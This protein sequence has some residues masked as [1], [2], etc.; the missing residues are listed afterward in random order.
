MLIAIG[1]LARTVN[2]LLRKKHCIIYVLVELRLLEPAEV[3]PELHA[4][5]PLNFLSRSELS[6]NCF[7]SQQIQKSKFAD[8]AKIKS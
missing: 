6:L 4:V 1:Y 7:V 2:I 3:L 5:F 8:L